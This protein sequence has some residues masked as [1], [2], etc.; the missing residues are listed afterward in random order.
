MLAALLCSASPIAVHATTQQYDLL[1]S[2]E[3]DD[4]PTFTN[5]LRI[6]LSYDD[7]IAGDCSSFTFMQTTTTNCRFGSQSSAFE[8][9]MGPAAGDTITTNFPVSLLT[10]GAIDGNGDVVPNASFYRLAFGPLISDDL[11]IVQ[12]SLGLAFLPSDPDSFDPNVLPIIDVGEFAQGFGYGPGG[13][14]NRIINASLT[15][16]TPPSTVPL[17][18]GGALLAM[19]AAGMALRSAAKARRAAR[20]AA[21]SAA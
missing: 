17:P 15:D 12:D 9:L 3:T 21:T 4:A 11:G 6:Q 20:R 2:Y 1:L 7:A 18:A 5:E 8:F 10:G 13:F 16:N 14:P 19:A